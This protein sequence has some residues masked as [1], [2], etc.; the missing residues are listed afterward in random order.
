MSASDAKTILVGVDGSENSIDALIWSDALGSQAGIGVTAAKAWE[1]PTRRSVQGGHGS[2][3]SA[4]EMDEDVIAKLRKVSDEAG[5]ANVTCR[6]L[7]GPARHALQRASAEPEVT[8]L[9]LGTRG[10]GPIKGLLLGSVG[11]S[12]LFGTRCPLILVPRGAGRPRFDRVVIGLD[13]SPISES[14]TAWSARLCLALGASA[15]I[16][17]CIDPGAEHSSERL[18]ETMAREQDHLETASSGAFRNLGITHDAIVTAGDARRCLIDVA[19]KQEAGL[20]V[21][22]QRGKGQFDG[23]GGTASYLVRHSPLP[24]AIIPQPPTP[25][26]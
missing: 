10:L 1:H 5:C 8:M 20:I 7:R 11:R 14:V 17:W 16:L 18:D 24:L 12:L 6:A 22:G 19:L 2:D 25:R 23:L 15:T 26:A 13:F 3:L 9:V 21:I 4:D